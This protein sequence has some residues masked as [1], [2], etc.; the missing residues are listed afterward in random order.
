MPSEVAKDPIA[1]LLL[2]NLILLV[3]GT[4]RKGIERTPLQVHVVAM[5]VI[6]VLGAGS[7]LWRALAG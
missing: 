5:E 2:V 3:I 1:F 7:F 6:V 4:R